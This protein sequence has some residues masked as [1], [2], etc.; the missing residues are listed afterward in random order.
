M[1]SIIKYILKKTKLTQNELLYLVAVFI[2][3]IGNGM[4]TISISKIMY[5][6]TNTA[7][8]FGLIVI[9]ENIISVLV[10]LI[11]GAVVDRVNCKKLSVICDYLRGGL[12]IVSSIIIRYSDNVSFL[13]IALVFV[14][15]INAFYRPSNFRLVSGVASNV[16]KFLKINSISS[17]LLQLGQVLGAMLV[18]PILAVSNTYSLLG[19]NGITFLIAAYL[20]SL[21]DI[22]LFERDINSKQVKNLKTNVFM[23]I[24]DWINVFKLLKINKKLRKII[25]FS[26]ADPLTINFINIMLVPLVSYRYANADYMV[27]FLDGFFAIGA[28]LSICLIGVCVKFLGMDNLKYLGIV[29]QGG[30]FILLLVSE[31]KVYNVVVLFLLGIVSSISVVVYQ[32]LLQENIEPEFKGKVTSVRNLISSLISL[33]IIPLVTK[34]YDIKIELG[35]LVSGSILLFFG[36]I[37]FIITLKEKMLNNRI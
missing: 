36:G 7:T 3:N 6:K 33:I 31:Y 19:G 5:S 15:I 17:M 13:V 23:I 20:I 29:T 32:T 9:M 22:Q 25:S 16:D 12:F 34:M 30:L 14:N 24:N 8:A 11:A 35:I 37:V 2:S 21:T 1:E 4:Y 18:V 27:S 28:I 10:Q 26:L